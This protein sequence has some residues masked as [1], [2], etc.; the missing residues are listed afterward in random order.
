M[1]L[2]DQVSRVA[3][4]RISDGLLVEFLPESGQKIL[5]EVLLCLFLG[6]IADGD[7]RTMSQY[8]HVPQ[9]V[10]VEGIGGGINHVAQPIYNVNSSID[11]FM[12]AKYSSLFSQH[13]TTSDLVWLTQE[14]HPGYISS[15]LVL[16]LTPVTCVPDRKQNSVLT[17][18]Q[19][20]EVNK[21]HTSSMK[22]KRY[23]GSQ[24]Q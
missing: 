17:F 4:S 11:P 5:V 9:P 20:E 23:L 18:F 24:S 8:I 2:Q 12:S 15:F 3:F 14:D 7:D 6:R 22:L 10:H 19:K 13:I 1:I 16:L 21:I